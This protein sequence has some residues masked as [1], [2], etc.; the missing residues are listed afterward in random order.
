MNK[1]FRII[2]ILFHRAG[3]FTYRGV[4]TTPA[5]Y[6]LK[7]RKAGE[8]DEDGAPCG[9]YSKE[10]QSYAYREAEQAVTTT[11]VCVSPTCLLSA[12]LR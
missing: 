7:D 2:F 3:V 12:C 4:E 5:K 1:I 6:R 11:D 10:E 9:K 8:K